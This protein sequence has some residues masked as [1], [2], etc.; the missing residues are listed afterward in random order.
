MMRRYP[1]AS[2]LHY[3]SYESVSFTLPGDGGAVGGL[4]E[5]IHWEVLHSGRGVALIFLLGKCV[6]GN[7]WK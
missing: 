6:Q 5:G 4:D 1:F 7:L 2:P 3:S